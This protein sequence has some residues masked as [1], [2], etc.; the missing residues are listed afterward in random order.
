MTRRTALS[1]F[2]ALVVMTIAT[3]AGSTTTASAQQNPNCCTYTVVVRGIQDACLPVSLATRWACLPNTIITSYTS[4]GL[5]LERIPV[6][7][8]TPCPPGPACLLAGIS[9]DNSTFVGPNQSHRYVFGDCCYLLEYGFATT[10]CIVITIS[11]TP[12]L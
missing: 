2:I 8:T 3:L 12:C 11:A 6:P 4:N 7:T 10:G 9:L 5:F 1:T